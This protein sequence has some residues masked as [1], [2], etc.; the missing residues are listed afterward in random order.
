MTLRLDQLL[1]ERLVGGQVQVGEQHLALAHAVV[2]LGDRL[3]DLEHH[4]GVAPD[5]VGGVEDRGAGG[6]V[7]LVGDLGADAGVRLDEDLVAVRTSSCDADRGDAPP[8]TR[9][10]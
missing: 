3:L 7:L 6:D 10:S 9:G 4:L 8:G 1:G 2:L 5:V